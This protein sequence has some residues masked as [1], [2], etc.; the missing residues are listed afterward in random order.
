MRTRAEEAQRAEDDAGDERRLVT[1]DHRRPL[2]EGGHR[3]AQTT[4]DRA[5]H[6][7]QL[8]AGADVQLR[9][10]ADLDVADTFLL[11][12]L[13]QLERGALQ[14]LGVGQHGDRVPEAFEVLAQVAITWPEDELAQAVFGLRR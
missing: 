2:V 13:A 5:H 4:V 11:A 7:G 6:V 3:A 12:V 9:R 10:E 8:E 14:R 1:R